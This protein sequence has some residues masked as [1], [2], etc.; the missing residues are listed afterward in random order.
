M[1]QVYWIST[2][3]SHFPG[4]VP[5]EVLTMVIVCMYVCVCVCVCLVGGSEEFL[6]F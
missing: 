2:V 4:M 3:K 5:L 6:S 1:H